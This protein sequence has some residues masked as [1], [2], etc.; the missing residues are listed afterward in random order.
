MYL[1]HES[2]RS[3]TVFFSFYPVEGHTVLIC[4]VSGFP[5]TTLD[6]V[7]TGR[8]HRTQHTQSCSQLRFITGKG[9]KAQSARKARQAP[10]SFVP[11][12]SH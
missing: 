4:L 9:G 12:D 7:V 11:V 10:K 2:Y 8:T 3:D 1:G 5:K 6:L